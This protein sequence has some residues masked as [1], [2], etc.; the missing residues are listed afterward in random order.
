MLEPFVIQNLKI[1]VK[2]WGFNST[3]LY[4]W[5]VY[6]MFPRSSEH[7][8]WLTCTR[9]SLFCMVCLSPVRSPH[10]P[11]LSLL[12]FSQSTAAWY[13][14]WYDTWL[15]TCSSDLWMS[16][17]NHQMLVTSHTIQTQMYWTH[18]NY[19]SFLRQIWYPLFLIDLLYPM[20]NLLHVDFLNSL[21]RWNSPNL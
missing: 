17:Y 1:K 4:T 10:M 9:S 19:I 5:Q 8:L 18:L 12:T 21:L 20:W 13:D 7:D 2:T 3:E 15:L 11:S 16:P 6:I 14:S